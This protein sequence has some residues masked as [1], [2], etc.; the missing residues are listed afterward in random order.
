MYLSFRSRKFRSV[1]WH[2]VWMLILLLFT[3][4]IYT[5]VK[6]LDC[7]TL[8]EE[9]PFTP[10]WFVNANVKCFSTGQHAS[11]GLFALGVLVASV[12]GIAVLVM[13]ATEQ[14]TKPDWFRHMVEPITR[15]F[16]ESLKWWCGVELAKRTALIIFAVAF[17]DDVVFLALLLAAVLTLNGLFQ[18]YSSVYVN[19]LEM[20]Y[21]V[22][23]FILLCSKSTPELAD[24]LGSK[25]TERNS[26]SVCATSIE[27][28]NFVIFLGVLY[29]LPLFIAAVVLII[30]LVQLSLSFY[31][32]DLVPRMKE[33]KEKKKPNLEPQVS[34]A[35]YSSME[36]QRSRTQTFVDM[37]SCEAATPVV[38]QQKF[39]FRLKRP[40]LKES[41][42]RKQKKKIEAKTS[43]KEAID[44][45]SL[46]DL[47]KYDIDNKTKLEPEEPVV[48]Y[49]DQS[50]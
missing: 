4:A 38:L 49:L 46:E 41:G 36:V 43:I 48:T 9:S 42:S 17:K 15:P 23:T 30:Y 13:I 45:T 31:R 25:I 33:R 32:K 47:T 16:K 22:N 40:S 14:L 37:S 10:R 21:G 18:P 28:P 20:V 50:V 7:P 24:L 8:Q 26:S 29:Y 1:D 44:E 34:G 39:S 19:I 11:L 3:P 27:H 12:A 2:G 5:S 6:L 35:E